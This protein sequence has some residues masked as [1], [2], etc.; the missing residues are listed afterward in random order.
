MNVDDELVEAFLEES[1]E[2]LNQLDLDLVAL[3]DNPQDP[4]LLARIFRTIHTIKGTCGFLGFGNLEGLS[5]AG[6]DLLARLR[7]GEVILD[8]AIT[9]SLLSLVDEVRGVLATVAETGTEGDA[10]H[11]AVIADLRRHLPQPAEAA[12]VPPTAPPESAPTTP[13]TPAPAPATAPAPAPKTATPTA[14]PAPAPPSAAREESTVR[15]DVAVL[16]ALQDLV[17]ELTLARMRLGDFVPDDGPLALSYNRLTAIT[18]ELQDTVMRARL[19]PIATAT[20]RLRRIVRDVAAAEGKAVHLVIE[21]EDVTVDKA[22]NE[23]LR[24]PLVH[25][26]RNAVDHG[27]ESPTERAAAGK[28]AQA[29]LLI[30]AS[31]IGGGVHIDVT[32]DGRGI[33][34][35]RIVDKAIA[36]GRVTASQAASMT[37][38]ERMALLFQPGVSTAEQ[39][40]TISGRGVGMDVVRAGLEQVGGSIEVASDPGRGTSFRINVPLTLAILPAIIVDCGPCRFTVPQTDVLAVARVSDDEWDERVRTIGDARFLRYHGTLLPLID[41]AEFL[42]LEPNADRTSA[43]EI[44]VIRKL[45][46]SYGLIVD[47]VQDDVDAVVKPLPRA[48]RGLGQ[49]AGTTVLSDGR[50]SLILETSAPA[51]AAELHS[52]GSDPDVQAE[53]AVITNRPLLITVTVG[54]ERIA[55]PLNRVRRLERVEVAR[56]E[57]SGGHDVLQYHGEVL[58]VSDLGTLL[59]VD[60]VGTA[61]GG[62]GTTDVVVCRGDHPDLGLLVAAIGDIEQAPA[63]HP[64]ADDTPGTVG[65]YVLGGR[66]TRVLDVDWVAAQT[67]SASRQSRVPGTIGADHG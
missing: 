36:V 34:V 53:P 50:P 32:D 1:N 43:T 35:D 63:D 46:R 41:L 25:L 48:I 3:E 8:E 40:T 17:G 19:Q 47:A 20:G 2:N 5:H 30:K 55:I 66:V 62:R 60:P 56:L 23:I 51:A 28:A 31:L 52:R 37:D 11:S 49:Y 44:V 24:D 64:D 14:T 6:E 67:A 16:D 22:I 29:T 26:V 12:P 39:V 61:A 38:S 9:T 10:D 15:I 7:S 33:N 57:R 54:D 65:R 42:A 59:G 18:R 4:E 13:S 45:E 58:A 27:I 21:G